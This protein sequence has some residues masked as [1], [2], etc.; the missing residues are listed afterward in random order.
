MT[1][2]TTNCTQVAAD[3]SKHYQ[4]TT[5]Y[6]KN[7]INTDDVLPRYLSTHGILL[8]MCFPFSCTIPFGATHLAASWIN[9]DIGV[10]VIPTLTQVGLIL[11]PLASATTSP[12][13]CIYPTDAG[14]DL[15]DTDGCGPNQLDPHYGSHGAK[16][17]NV[18][19]R[20]LARRKITK[21]KTLN[22]G[23]DTEWMDIDC[24][25][26]FPIDVPGQEH[27]RNW[28][29]IWNKE[30]GEDTNDIVYQSDYD[31][32]QEELEAIMGHPVCTV[33]D[34]DIS[35]KKEGF[36]MYSGPTSWAPTDWQEMV[37]MELE[38]LQEWKLVWNEV[39]LE[40][41][42]TQLSDVVL[43]VFYL[44]APEWNDETRQASR[45]LAQREAKVL[46]NKPV[47]RLDTK[48][49]KKAT[50]TTADDSS[51]H[52]IL[53]CGEEAP[54]EELPISNDVFKEAKQPQFLRKVHPLPS[55]LVG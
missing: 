25:D 45:V 15:R 54:I 35:P 14:S 53:T 55:L 46:G 4:D 8:T 50:T 21:Y 44:D 16:S 47:F 39:V 6:V 13:K 3:L 26:F 32:W 52:D 17:Y 33:P 27:P 41:P 42:K 48:N 5:P 23:I 11:D 12:I 36:R 38:F 51:D 28:H 9:A 7:N 1:T 43:G 31:I 49:S 20:P 10:Q 34:D 22:F 37:K 30:E 2:P 29:R 40:L 24:R 18:V 19:T